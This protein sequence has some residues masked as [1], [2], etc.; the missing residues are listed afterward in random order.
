M[1]RIYKGFEP[2]NETY[3]FSSS[4][5]IIEEYVPGTVFSVD[6]IIQDGKLIFSAV[7]EF[8]TTPGPSLKQNAT[9]IP[10]S[11]PPG[12]QKKCRVAAKKVIKVLKFDNCGFHIEMAL[13][14][15]GPILIEAA[16]RLPGG[17]ILEAYQKVYKVNLVSLLLDMALGKKLREVKEKVYNY[18]IIEA[19]FTSESGLITKVGKLVCKISSKLMLMFYVDKG[20]IINEKDSFSSMYLYFMLSNK[21]KEQLLE[22]RKSINKDLAITVEKNMLY[23]LINIRN[24]IFTNFSKRFILFSIIILEIVVGLFFLK[25]IYSSAVKQKQIKEVA[26]IDQ[27]LL[28]QSSD[29]ELKYFYEPEANQVIKDHQEWLEKDVEYTINNDS[30]NE[31]FDYSVV[32]PPS[33]F[34]IMTIGDSHTF[35]HFVNTQDNYPEKMEDLLLGMNTQGNFCPSYSNIEVINLGM[36]GYDVEYTTHRYQARGQKYSPDA[37]LWYIKD[38][39]FTQILEQVAPKI[40]YLE[41]EYIKRDPRYLDDP[42]KRYSAWID[43]NAELEKTWGI[44]KIINYNGS[45]VKDFLSNLNIPLVFIAYYD[46]SRTPSILESYAKLFSNVHLFI[47]TSY[48][49]I[50][51]LADGHPSSLGYTK[52]SKSLTNYLVNNQSWLCGNY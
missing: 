40:K 10:S 34:R 22:D 29:L 48:A 45:I 15:T 35:G 13:T 52:L 44:D 27:R 30:L 43:A 6:G 19:N 39:D 23:W 25:Y 46:D 32:K 18:V 1:D 9:I 14:K 7:T 42:S 17:K 12:I 4:M 8:E 47:E 3:G 16:S 37:I 49:D 21:N 26:T 5:F 31:R 38:D 33:T 28:K 20:I 51:R 11:F 24:S 36:M 50:D 2:M 41:K